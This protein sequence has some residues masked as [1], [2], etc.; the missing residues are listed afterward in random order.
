MPATLRL[1]AAKA[2]AS[3]PQSSPDI[4]DLELSFD[5]FM[6]AGPKEA[7]QAPPP[8][9]RPRRPASA[10]ALVADLCLE[11]ALGRTG[12]RLLRRGGPSVVVLRVPGSAW[13]DAI[14]RAVRALAPPGSTIVTATSRRSGSLSDEAAGRTIAKGVLVVGIAP[15]PDWL[16]PTLVAAADLQVRVDLPDPS[17]IDEAIRRWCRRR[18][19]ADLALDD[20][21]G[22]DLPDYD[23]ALRPGSTPQDCVARLRR[24]ARLRS[25]GHARP[26]VPLLTALSGCDAARDWALEITAE[27]ERARITAARPELE[28]CMFY[29]PPGTGKTL[30]AHALS[31]TAGIPMVA[32]SVAEWFSGSPGYLDSV[33]KQYV[34]FFGRLSA[35]A[36]VS[37]AGFAL[38]FIDECDAIPD[39]SSMS[40]RSSS[41]WTTLVTGL[42]LE[43]DRLRRLH[44]NVLLV[45]ATNHLARLDPALL[46]PGRFDRHIEIGPPDEEGRAGILRTHLGPDLHEADLLRVARL[47]P[48]ATGAALAGCVRAARRRARAG[49]R[50]LELQ[51][52]L[53]EIVPA[54]PRSP[55]EV[56]EVALH[57]AGHAVLALKL[58]LRVEHVTVQ[59]GQVEAGHTRIALPNVL[60]DRAA[61]EAQVVA[62]LAGRAADAILGRGGPNAG[63]VADLREATRLVAAIHASFGLGDT[64]AHRAPHEEAEL[65]LRLDPK[66]TAVVEADLRRLMTRAVALVREH[67]HSIRTVAGALVARRTLVGM[68]LTEIIARSEA[69]AHARAG[70]QRQRPDPT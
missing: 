62:M 51:D 40:D 9:K 55:D 33:I 61:L 18:A 12:R 63:A 31:R 27:I 46:R 42:L 41:W 66:L 25:P 5:S 68:D 4:T 54:D 10:A 52:L 53:A 45:G 48:Q 70:D 30:I 23:A 2:A 39:R 26:D 36:S 35:I 7:D 69:H 29:G 8:P 11:R 44:P 34:D 6:E 57:E 65:L 14:E 56:R 49:G 13:V 50:D 58:G 59:P 67:E 19:G 43:I 3:A 1:L 32:T 17:V 16:G 60:P 47:C 15:M 37:S 20:L 21:T 22:L 38:G 64:L 24:A 28:S